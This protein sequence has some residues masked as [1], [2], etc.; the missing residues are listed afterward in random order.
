M[1]VD[2]LDI[3]KLIDGIIFLI[4]PGYL[5]SFILFKNF[6]FVERIIFGFAL[7]LGVFSCGMFV[8]DVLLGIRLSIIITVLLLTIYTIPSII[9]FIYS[10]TKSYESKPR[11][12]R[13]KDP[14][15]L[16]LILILAFAIFM[17][18]L[19]HVS[20]HFYLPFHVDEWVH[21][22]TTRT[23]MEQGSSIFIDPYTGNGVTRSLESG[24]H[25]ITAGLI[26]LTG[27]NFNTIFVFMPSIIAF[28]ISLTAFAIGDRSERK[29][30]LEAALFVS[31]VPTSCRVLGPSFFV[32]LTMALFFLIFI[33]WLVS[34]KKF[35]TILFIPFFIWCAFL[36]HPPTALACIIISFMFGF[37]FF[38]EKEYKFSL[39]VLGFSLIPVCAVFLLTSMWGYALQQVIDAF[40]VGKTFLD[41]YNLPQ[42]WPS[43]EHLGYLTWILCI[44]GVYTA[45][46]KGKSLQRTFVLS[47]FV[48]IIIIGLY[49]KFGYGIIIMYERSFI[50]LFLIVTL[51]GGWGLSELRRIINENS[52]KIPLKH[53]QK[54]YKHMGV[55]VSVVLCLSLMITVIP[56]HCDIPYYQMITENEF[57]TFSWIHDNINSIRDKTHSYDTGV[58]DPFK[59]APFSAITGLYIISS[60]MSPIY[61]YNLHSEVEQFLRDQCKN[62]SFLQKYDISVIYSSDCDNKNLTVVYPNVYLYP[63]L[64]Y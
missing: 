29:F 57:E 14:K 56:A 9:F 45:F 61:G 13:L 58:I 59:A 30:G 55:L 12:S 1:P 6:R 44:V 20:N 43:F 25:Y 27:V 28:F 5:W 18:F 2:F 21:W 63:G 26:W 50:Y 42:I 38:L 51:L 49:D 54:F 16:L 33:I 53:Y 36:I 32:P 62:T 4:I 60:T 35:F 64:S 48:F 11:L 40:F 17:G 41:V 47:A 3:T 22:Q 31:F 15:F 7:S 19:P 10:I 34:V 23:V 8:I 24:F 39:L 46:A 52:E 37:A